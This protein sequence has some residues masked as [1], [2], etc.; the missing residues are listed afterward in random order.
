[1]V[2]GRI[3]VVP[4][5]WKQGRDGPCDSQELRNVVLEGEVGIEGAPLAFGQA[6]EGEVAEGA[7][8]EFFDGAALAGEHA[9]DLVVFSFFELEAGGAGAGDFECGGEAGF[10]F[11][12]EEEGA[13][14]E[15]I[16]Q[17]FGE[18]A[19]FRDG[20]FVGFADLVF[21]RG[22]AMGE[23]SVVGDEDEAA[24]VAVEPAD[25]DGAGVAA[26][27]SGGEEVV[28]EGG[29]GGVVG[30]GVA[31]GLVEEDEEAVRKFHG[32]SVDEHVVGGD[33]PVATVEGLGVKG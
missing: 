15:K 3:A 7:A 24:G 12:P 17:V 31:E 16:A 32:G 20:D 22:E 4:D 27:P 29:F 10:G 6:F 33:F 30:A 2:H 19:V 8:V 23:G 11:A 13:G 5:S 9:A 18:D 26:E 25:A 28:E 1:M 21:G 14:L